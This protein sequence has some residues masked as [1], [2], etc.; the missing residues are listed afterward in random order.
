MMMSMENW[1][2]YTDRGK[3]KYSEKILCQCNFVHHK[4]QRNGSGSN[5]I[6]RGEMLV[7]NRPE[8]CHELKD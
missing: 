4:A 2:N 3:L 6:I 1:W 8:L 5:P 7:S